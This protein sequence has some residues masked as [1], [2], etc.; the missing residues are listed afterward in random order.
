MLDVPASDAVICDFDSDGKLELGIIEKFHGDVLSIYRINDQG[1]YEKCWEY[2][3]KLEMLH[4]I[5]A[6]TLCGKKRFV[7]GNRRGNRKTIA[8]SW[9]AGEYQTEIIEENTGAANILHFMNKEGKDIIV[10][11]N[12]EINEVA[13]FIFEK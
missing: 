6:G 13:M 8:V 7:V 9:E 1:K 4:A 3:E 11:A 5:W 10:A 2:P 12:R